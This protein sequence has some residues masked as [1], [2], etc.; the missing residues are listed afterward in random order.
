MNLAPCDYQMAGAHVQ[1]LPGCPASLYW[2]GS[3]VTTSSR[4]SLPKF[5]KALRFLQ[6]LLSFL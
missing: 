1:L 5:N 4:A 6:R 3:S 2:A